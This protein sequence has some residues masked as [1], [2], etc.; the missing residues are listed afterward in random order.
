[1][2]II[3]TNLA[4]EQLSHLSGVTSVARDA[5]RELQ[6]ERLKEAVPENDVDQITFIKA[7]I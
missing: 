4:D 5:V 1:M 2:Q 6:R 3:V 7:W